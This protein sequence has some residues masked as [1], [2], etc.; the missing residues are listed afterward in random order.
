MPCHLSI[1]DSSTDGRKFMVNVSGDLD[2]M[3]VHGLQ[4]SLALALRDGHSPVVADVSGVT[5]IDSTGVGA[6]ITA[7]RTAMGRLRIVGAKAHVKHVFET[8]GMS[9]LLG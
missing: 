1:S 6:L 2:L 9:E 7:Y 4:D 8:I 5:F 3:T